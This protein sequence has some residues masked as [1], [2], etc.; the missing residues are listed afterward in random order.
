[1][2]FFPFDASAVREACEELDSWRSRLDRRAGFSRRWLGRMR[3]D[4]EAEA[5]AASVGM[6]QVP[7]TVDEVRR[8]LVG[9]RPASVRP[10][11]QELVRGYREAMEFVL[12]RADDPGFRWTRELVT[13][14]HD[15][16]LAGNYAAEAGRFATGTRWVVN[17]LT[18]AVVF[19][20]ADHD[21]IPRLVDQLCNELEQDAGHP[22]VRS[23]WAHVVLAAIHPFRDGNGRVAR[24]S[25]SLAMYRGGFRRKEFTSLEEWWG[26][27][28]TDYY[29][30]FGCLGESFDSNVDVTSFIDAHVRAQ[31]SQVRALDLRER[32]ERTIWSAL[33][34]IVED[35]NLQPR[36]VNAVWDA[37]FDRSVTPAYY[38]PLA[39]VSRATATNDFSAA[40]SAGLLVARGAGRGRHYIATPELFRRLGE[41]LRI[42]VHDATGREH[43]I[44][45]LTRELAH[46][47]ET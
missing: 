7:V 11:D 39:D 8:I 6:E 33:E 26:R 32:I 28:L 9:E 10:E 47:D 14:L 22:A 3:R 24:V 29:A 16:V 15:R 25:A 41:S 4:L 17:R 37:F 20:P 43:V 1:M 45:A 35:S 42:E 40:V 46:P 13:G 30:A 18:G 31:L 38:I 12:R 44:A 5:V 34:V 21:N 23:A 27:H 36:V 19:A 2:P